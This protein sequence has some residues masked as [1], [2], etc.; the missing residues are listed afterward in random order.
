MNRGR[1]RG[2]S[3]DQ[4]GN[5]AR[6]SNNG[7]SQGGRFQSGRRAFNDSYDDDGNMN[8]HLSEKFRSPYRGDGGFKRGSNSNFGPTVDLN[9]HVAEYVHKQDAIYDSN[10]KD[11]WHSTPEIP[12]SSEI[13][14]EEGNTITLPPNKI[15]RPWTKNER[16]LKT[17]YKL[18]RE[19]ATAS[20]REAVDKFKKDPLR[21]DDNDIR[22]YEQVRVVGLT[23]NN[24]GIATRIRFSTVRSGRKILWSSSK[25]LVSG[26][27]VALTPTQD[28][29]RTRC[30]LATVAARPLANVEV[31]PPEIDIF[32]ARMDDHEVD[33][34]QTF[35][36]IEAT[37]G[38][39]EAYRHTLRALQ[40]QSQET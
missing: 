13:C 34:Q 33:P 39:Y 1:G 14:V 6:A 27:L 37:Q 3:Q 10:D 24:K 26:T 30:I 4:N 29:F 16:Y 18:L 38:Y 25:R 28:A 8:S 36:M 31:D 40:K 15:D 5:R 20:L 12:L 19:D 17:H 23:F 35:V 7:R 21:M 2:Q 9:P 32:F 11:D 22:I